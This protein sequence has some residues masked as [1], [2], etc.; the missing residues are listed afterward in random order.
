MNGSLNQESELSGTP[1]ILIEPRRALAAANH[2]I[3][4][5]RSELVC[6]V[7]LAAAAFQMLAV[8]RRKNI[9]VDEIVMIPSA[10]YHL[11]AGNFQLVNE[12]PP[13]AKFLAA[14]PLL[15][16]QPNEPQPAELMHFWEATLRT[17]KRFRF[18]PAY[19]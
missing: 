4:V 7:L 9:T 3:W 12:H 2:W 5:H 11:V 19:R 17:L 13:L 18:G 1:L 14:T 10:Y 16:V 15:L 6:A 8:V